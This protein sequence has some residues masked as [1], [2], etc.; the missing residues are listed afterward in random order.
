[1]ESIRRTH[2]CSGI[3]SRTSEII[4]AGWSKGTNTAYQSGW[5]KWSGWC[6]QRSLKPL[7]CDGQHFLELLELFDSGQHR[8]INVIR[9]A[10]SM[11]HETIEGVPIGQHPLVTRLMRG[12]YNLRPPR[13]RYSSTRDVEVVAQH[14]VS[15]GENSSLS[16]KSL[17]QK[18]AFDG[19]CSGQQSI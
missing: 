17:S 11:T 13:P 4:S 1:M 15:M 18:L 2:S 6:D 14:I 3:S 5:V 8:S 9:S 16:L 10:V 19:P 7:S 12:V